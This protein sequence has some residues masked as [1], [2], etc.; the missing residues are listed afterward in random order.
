MS[1]HSK[2]STIKRQKGAADLKR[3]ASF[4]K[5]SNAITLAAKQGGSTDPS[6][7]FRLRL[8]IEAAK[9][10]NMPKDT[11]D[12]AIA[13][14]SG[15]EGSVIQELTYEGFAPG[16][17][18]VMVET[19]TDNPNRTGSEVKGV[20]QRSGAS[21][22]QPG[23]VAYLFQNKGLIILKKD[24]MS[25]DEIFGLA[26]ESGAEDVQEVGDEVDVYTS[27]KDLASVREG[28]ISKGLSVFASELIRKPTSFVSLDEEGSKKVLNFLEELDSMDD[29]QKVYSN[30]SD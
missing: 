15:R 22:G 6:Q 16:G 30:L 26:A 1:G 21:F 25:F 17:V 23:S 3:G 11:I 19:A 5:H 29:V 7:N 9:A 4:T 12:R 24:T 28:L 2:W 8:A 27:P 13:R 10:S 14:A 18:A 20:F